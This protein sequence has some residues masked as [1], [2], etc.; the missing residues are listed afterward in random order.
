MRKNS[1]FSG[2]RWARVMRDGN[3]DGDGTSGGGGDAAAASS[4]TQGAAAATTG[5]AGSDKGFPENTPVAEMQPEQQAAYWKH[6]SRKWEGQAK[7]NPTP[8][9]IAD[10]KAKAD[11]HDAAELAN[12]T[13]LE[14]ERTK[15]AELAK[16]NAEYELKEMQRAAAKAADLSLED[17]EFVTATDAEGAKAQAEK[18]AARLK[19]AAKETGGGSGFQQGFQGDKGT[20][21]SDVASGRELY[22]QQ[23][24]NKKTA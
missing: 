18:L 23:H 8:A 14:R 22:R 12:M 16:K 10:L 13:E 19:A 2:T 1:R 3:R 9:E 6:M 5:D 17:Y 15:N 21:T 7:Q 24:P 11:A 20:K 4:S